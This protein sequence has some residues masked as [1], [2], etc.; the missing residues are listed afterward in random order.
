MDP[1]WIILVFIAGAAVGRFWKEIK[2]WANRA[3]GY[4]LDGINR[5]TEVTSD[6]IVYL[7]KEGTRRI[8]KKMEV[9]VKDIYTKEIKPKYKEESIS[10]SEV[11]DEIKAQLDQ[12]EAVKLMQLE[13]RI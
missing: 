11:P 12:K 5:A 4:I 9:W 8:Y 2:E 13:N 3:L 6:A 1:I 7:V 10:R